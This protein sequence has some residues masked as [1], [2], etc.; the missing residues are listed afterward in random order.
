MTTFA[1][2][3][4]TMTFVSI[5]S[6]IEFIDRE[7]LF[8]INGAHTPLTDNLFWTATRTVSWIPFYLLAIFAIWYCYRQKAWR[9]VLLVILAVCVSDIVSSGIIKPLVHR[10]R[11]T[12]TP[13]LFDRL[14]FF[15]RPNGKVYYGGVNSFPSSHAAN[16]TTVAM[17]LFVSLRDSVG[18]K[19]PLVLCLASYVLL[20]SYTRPYLGVHY[21]SD[22]LMGWLVGLTV[23]MLIVFWARRTLLAPPLQRGFS[24]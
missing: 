9:V 22:I 12:H 14:R 5:I 21:P 24:A 23:S 16:S 3:I 6:Y 20:F 8:L 7:L 18:K 13:E 11:P 10:P 4:I 2:Y 15:V 19:W 17:L 1:A